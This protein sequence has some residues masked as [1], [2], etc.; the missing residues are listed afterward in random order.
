MNKYKGNICNHGA[1][2]EWCNYCKTSGD[3][4][5]KTPARRLVINMSAESTTGNETGPVPTRELS[6]GQKAVGLTFNPGNNP[7]V[8]AIKEKFAAAIDVLNDLRDGE[9]KQQAV[10]GEKIRMYSV[11][12]TELQ[13]AQMWAVKAATWQY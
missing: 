6:F 2:L 10:N 7:T 13:S 1:P 9:K 3:F 4:F 5:R 8:D 12:I 11:A